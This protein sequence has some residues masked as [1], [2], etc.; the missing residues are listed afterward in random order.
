MVDPIKPHIAMD[1]LYMLIML[2]YYH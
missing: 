2:S 1:A